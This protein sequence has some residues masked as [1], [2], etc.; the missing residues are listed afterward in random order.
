M[1][2]DRDPGAFAELAR[3]CQELA[4]SQATRDIALARITMVMAAKGG[5][6]AGITVGDCIEI[7]QL[8][9]R[10]AAWPRRR[11]CFGSPFYQLLRSLGRV[12]R[13]GTTDHPGVQRPR[14]DERGGD[15]RP[16]RHGMKPVR[17][18]LIDYLRE[19]LI[20]SDFSTVLAL[21][22]VLG[23]LFW[24][25]WNCTTWASAPCTCCRGRLGLEAAAGHQEDQDH[26]P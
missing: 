9:T 16:V 2:R 6:A 23:K 20:S 14:T 13:D 7:H 26:R 11:R 19:F 12:P 8:P 25:I 18:L 24:R 21:S 1:A 5:L 3:I 17:D 10:S 15:H 22:Y 4:A